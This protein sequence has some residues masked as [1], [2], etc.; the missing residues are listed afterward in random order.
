MFFKSD[1]AFHIWHFDNVCRKCEISSV[2]LTVFRYLGNLV[3]IQLHSWPLAGHSW[4]HLRFQVVEDFHLK[5]SDR[6]EVTAAT[7]G[8]VGF[9]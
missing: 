4:L 1:P 6:C 5:A 7:G 2:I 3:P 9:F 8:P